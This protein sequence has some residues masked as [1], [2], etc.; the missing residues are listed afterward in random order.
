MVA[1]ET[2]TVDD[3]AF[4][5]VPSGCGPDEASF[6]IAVFPALIKGAAENS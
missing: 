1:S 6:E 3:V 5:S 2:G 4:H